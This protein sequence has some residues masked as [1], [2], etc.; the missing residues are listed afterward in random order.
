MAPNHHGRSPRP[1]DTPTD[2]IDSAAAQAVDEA[3]VG[4]LG[5]INGKLDQILERLAKGDT[6]IAL[7]EHRVAFLEKIV[8]GLCGII[9]VSVIGAIVALVVRGSP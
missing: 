9:L 6:A 2:R 8:Y 4:P 3:M 5:I 1:E 7:L